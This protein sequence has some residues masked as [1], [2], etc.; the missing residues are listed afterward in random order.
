M[1]SGLQLRFFTSQVVLLGEHV[2]IFLRG[3][4]LADRQ[5]ASPRKLVAD[6]QEA[7]RMLS[8]P[9]FWQEKLTIPPKR[10]G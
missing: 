3:C 1:G 7:S 6:R 5:E 4:E 8:P 9:L 10:A 2:A